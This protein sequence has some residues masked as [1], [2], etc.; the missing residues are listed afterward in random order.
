[1][2]LSKIT[3]QDKWLAGTMA[4]STNIH[5]QNWPTAA[6][7]TIICKREQSEGSMAQYTMVNNIRGQS[8]SVGSMALSKIINQH[9]WLAGTM[10]LSKIFN[11]RKW[12]TGSMAHPQNPN[13]ILL[14]VSWLQG[15]VQ[16]Y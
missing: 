15:S 5:P 4:Q 7:S 12:P 6:L 14:A 1:M 16:N 3:N 10:A 2:G 11:Q 13:S 9:K 8:G